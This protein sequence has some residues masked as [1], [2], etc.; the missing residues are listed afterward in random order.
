MNERC[1]S[2]F[3]KRNIHFESVDRTGPSTGN[4]SG[5]VLV[6]LKHELYQHF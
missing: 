3:E 6:I 4:Y 2:H 1:A 5:K